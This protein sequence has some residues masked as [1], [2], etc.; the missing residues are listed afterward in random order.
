M[1]IVFD[2]GNGISIIPVK[3]IKYLGLGRLLRD[4]KPSKLNYY[5]GWYVS[6][7]PI[8]DENTIELIGGRSILND[9]GAIIPLLQLRSMNNEQLMEKLA[10]CEVEDEIVIVATTAPTASIATVVNSCLKKEPNIL[11]LVAMKVKFN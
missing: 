7:E 10:I 4:K 5:K 11:P 2:V 9:F 8:S 6:G 1:E 3:I